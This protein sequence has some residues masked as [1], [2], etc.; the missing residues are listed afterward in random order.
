MLDEKVTTEIS[1][2]EKPKGMPKNKKVAKRG[3]SVAGKARLE[4]ER[5]LK[6][7][8]ISK[9]NYLPPKKSVRKL[10]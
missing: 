2:K 1:K 10:K 7:S 8:V 5:E 6:R 9:K 3:G 4:T